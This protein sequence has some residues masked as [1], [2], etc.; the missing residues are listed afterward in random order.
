[1][2][3][4]HF[5]INVSEPHKM[6]DWF[7]EHCQL[8]IVSRMAESPYMTFLADETDRVI[9]ELYNNPADEVPDYPNQH[10]V[11]VHI[12]F[13]VKDPEADRTRL[14]EVGCT[15]FE[16][17]TKDDGTLLIMMRN[18]WGVPIQLCKRG[19]PFKV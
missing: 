7:V 10:P 6:A 2:I 16:T 4:E 1:M 18:P 14:E 12:A 15:Y 8:K 5:A 9:M 17:V 19:T 13:E 3:F 11:R